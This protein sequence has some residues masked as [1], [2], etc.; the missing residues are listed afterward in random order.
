MHYRLTLAI[1]VTLAICAAPASSAAEAGEATAPNLA[2]GPIA[3][4]ILD[5]LDAAWDAAD[6]TRFAA[7]FTDDADVINIFGEAYKGRADLARRMQLIFDGLFKGSRHAG[8]ELEMARYLS[9]DTILI[10]SSSR[11]AVPSGPLSPETHNR[12][13][14]ILVRDGDTWRIRHWHNTTIGRP[15]A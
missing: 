1:A 6:G 7:E 14:F 8:R 12:Q 2:A 13:T 4:P 10:V 11:V 9:P 15:G 5:R 3:D